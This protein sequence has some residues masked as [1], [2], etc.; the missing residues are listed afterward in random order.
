[1]EVKDIRLYAFVA[2]VLLAQHTSL[3]RG[4]LA[5]GAVLVPIVAFETFIAYD[6]VFACL[7]TGDGLLA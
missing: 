7:A 5:A 6:T 4:A 1:M 2:F 3:Q